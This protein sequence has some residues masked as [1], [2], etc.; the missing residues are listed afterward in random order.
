M[1]DRARL[2]PQLGEVFRAHGYE[3]ASLALISQATALGKG[4]LYHFFPGGKQQMAAEVLAEIDAWFEHNIFAPL[5]DDDD[6]ARAIAAMLKGV[7]SYFRSGN[8]VCLVGVIALGHARDIFADA[9]NGYF[10]RWQDALVSALRR[11]GQSP[12]MARKRSEDALLTIQGALV[13]ARARDDAAIF[14][15]ALADLKARLLA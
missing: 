12:A 8:R 13:L 14:T 15:R 2:L 6:P 11:T 4:S 7:D 10:A 9:V 1:T 5:R 3:G